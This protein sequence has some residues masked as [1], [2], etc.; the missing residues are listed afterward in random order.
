MIDLVS[1]RYDGWYYY[2][3]WLDESEMTWVGPFSNFL[4]AND[5]MLNAVR[6][7]IG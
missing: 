7:V 1:Y 3:Y 2:T 6:K 5:A 4:D